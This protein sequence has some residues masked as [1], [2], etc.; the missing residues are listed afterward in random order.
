MPS[1]RKPSKGF[2]PHRPE[3]TDPFW[4]RLLTRDLA[5]QPWHRC[6]GD[7]CD[8]PEGPPTRHDRVTRCQWMFVYTGER[9]CACEMCS[10]RAGRRANTKRRRRE[11]RSTIDEQVRDD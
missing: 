8:L 1:Q 9:V 11:D 5:S 4:V 10:D 6:N 7:D 2:K 3:R